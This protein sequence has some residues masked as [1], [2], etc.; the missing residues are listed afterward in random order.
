MHFLLTNDDGI[1]APG[2]AALEAAVNAMGATCKVVAPAV[3]QSQC[4]HRVTTREALKVE[5]RDENHYA[6]HGTPADCVRIA[7]FGLNL[8]PDAVLSGVNQGGNM[9]QDIAI[10]G[11]VA[12]VRE[13]AYHGLK[14]LAFSHYIIG[15]VGF[16][17]PRVS[18]WTAEMLRR[19]LAEPLADGEYWNVNF[20]HLPPGPLPLPKVLFSQPARS[21]LAVSFLSVSDNEDF[22]LYQYNARYAHRPQDEGSDVKACFSGKVSVSKLK[23]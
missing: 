8:K 18:E 16:D 9:G 7:L 3:E 17:W 22:S 4:G 19:L 12:A 21:P 2:L 1:H 14:A 13:A 6:V 20:P 11:T 23:L 15:D 10:S 5:R